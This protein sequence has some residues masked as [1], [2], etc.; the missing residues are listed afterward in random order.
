MLNFTHPEQTYSHVYRRL[1]S[2]WALIIGS[3][4]AMMKL[5]Y[6]VYP[7]GTDANA[8]FESVSGARFYFFIGKK[9]A[10]LMKLLEMKPGELWDSLAIIS[11][12]CVRDDTF[13]AETK[14][15]T[16][17]DERERVMEDLARDLVDKITGGFP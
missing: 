12:N 16:H 17:I 8:D 2:G 1:I 6:A 10:A 3:P 4:V 14:H 15:L 7:P 5:E 11:I 9:T 13:I